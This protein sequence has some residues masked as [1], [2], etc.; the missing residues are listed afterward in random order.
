MIME[1]DDEDEG[2]NRNL[3]TTLASIAID[4]AKLVAGV[5]RLIIRTLS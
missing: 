2:K 5:P 4:A 1:P 3:A